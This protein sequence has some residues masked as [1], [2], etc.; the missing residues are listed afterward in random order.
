MNEIPDNPDQAW[1]ARTLIELRDE[2]RALRDEL[3]RLGSHSQLG[4][5]RRRQ[6]GPVAL[7]RP[8]ADRLDA[9]ADRHASLTARKSQT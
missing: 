2:V 7:K 5:M 8:S 1:F 9:P 3:V 6:G 4:L